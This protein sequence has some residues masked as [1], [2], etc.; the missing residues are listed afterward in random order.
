MLW[1]Y[2]KT[3]GFIIDDASIF[4]DKKVRIALRELY[5][6]DE[7]AA[8]DLV[9][10]R[11]VFE[12]LEALA[13][14]KSFM[15]DVEK[16]MK[17]QL[18]NETMASFGKTVSETVIDILKP[19]NINKLDDATKTGLVDLIKDLANG[20]RKLEDGQLTKEMKDALKIF[21][22]QARSRVD[23]AGKKLVSKDLLSYKNLSKNKN[24]ATTFDTASQLSSKSLSKLYA[25]AQSAA[26]K[27]APQLKIARGQLRTLKALY[28][29]RGTG[30]V[31]RFIT[32]YLAGNKILFK[33]L[34]GISNGI[35]KV[36]MKTGVKTNFAQIFGRL[37]GWL[38]YLF[39]AKL[40]IP[41]I[42]Y[43]R[44]FQPYC[45]APLKDYF[46]TVAALITTKDIFSFIFNPAQGIITYGNI[47]G[48]YKKL[49][50]GD[51]YSPQ[52]SNIFKKYCKDFNDLASYLPEIREKKV[53]KMFRD[54]M[55][56]VETNANKTFNEFK[57]YVG[58]QGKVGAKEF[59]ELD[60]KAKKAARELAAVGTKAQKVTKGAGK[61]A[62]DV[63]TGKT[64]KPVQDLAN[65]AGETVGRVVDAAQK[66]AKAVIDRDVNA[67]HS[68]ANKEFE[69][70]F[71]PAPEAATPTTKETISLSDYREKLLEERLEKITVRLI[72]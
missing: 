17:T 47:R 61:L 70:L 32:Q 67:A 68:A 45:G 24:F 51:D 49:F 57:E 71:A 10:D 11:L 21:V 26:A 60:A 40:H 2:L 38:S 23:T 55:I 35:Q 41:L 16:L 12:Q 65:K 13:R 20:T 62:V 48:E 28:S 53:N 52:K 46:S 22:T 6:V 37:G 3:I 27:A 30:F 36:V 43:V 29:Q 18:P 39:I 64:P 34:G 50:G 7:K 31:G 25:K 66:K 69:S 8:I 4:P 58:V 19:E 15:S 72:K 54:S 44:F 56:F 63:A 33:M 14:N 59:K 9:T 1:V 5:N 42:A